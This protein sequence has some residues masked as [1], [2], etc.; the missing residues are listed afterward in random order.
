MEKQLKIL[1][2]NFSG[3]F[4]SDEFI[5]HQLADGLKNSGQI[6]KVICLRNSQFYFKCKKSGIEILETELKNLKS[7]FRA[8]SY[9]KR[10]LKQEKADIIHSSSLRDQSI[11]S[12]AAFFKKI[13]HI[14]SVYDTT[15]QRAEGYIEKKIASRSLRHY[16][17]GSR[18]IKEL[19]IMG[20]S[21]NESIISVVPPGLLSSDFIKN[22]EKRRRIRNLFGFADDNVI[23]GSIGNFQPFEGQGNLLRA[24]AEVLPKFPRARI[25]FV[26][27]GELKEGLKKTSEQLGIS[28]QVVFTGNREDL[29]SMYSCFDIYAQTY[30]DG[31]KDIFPLTV[32]QAMVYKLPLI[33]TNVGDMHEFIEPNHNGYLIAD[34]KHD[35]L[36]EILGIL[37]ADEKLRTGMSEKSYELFERRFSSEVTIPKIINIYKSHY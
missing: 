37:I 34:R 12:A 2:V 11:C 32:L 5:L 29:S 1:L 9:L 31:I 3:S 22:E 4:G 23:I 21:I 13:P 15:F 14:I 8:V 18:G 25:I 27:D 19:L 24:F 33:L 7:K 28:S 26:G 35:S 6:V 36:V 30:T 10:I 16:I 17:A 20:R